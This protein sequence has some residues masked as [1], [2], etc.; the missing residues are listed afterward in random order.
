[1]T[2]E[3]HVF[4]T[5][6]DFTPKFAWAAFQLLAELDQD[7]VSPTDLYEV[8]QLTASP[9]AKRADLNKLLGALQEVGLIERAHGTITLSEAG[10]ALAVS[11]GRYEQSFYAA[12]HGIYAWKWI[13][14]GRDK[15]ASP[16]W[17]YREACRQILNSEV[18]GVTSDE[19]VLRVVATAVELFEVDRVSFSRSSVAGI[20]VWLEAQ[21]PPLIQR[22]S[23]RIRIQDAFIYTSEAMRLHLASLCALGNGQTELN[24]K[25]IQMLAECFLY[26]AEEVYNAVLDF[27][28]NSPEFMLLS[29]APYRVIFKNSDEPFINWIINKAVKSN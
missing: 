17:S 9:L 8:A 27:A 19:L 25:S 20:T 4:H 3:N 24:N 14:E 18:L 7:R 2:L 16:S 10:Q 1:M 15:I 23:Q 12:L 11:L 5:K 26:N 28:H 13:W 29:G 6:H 22:E 21:A